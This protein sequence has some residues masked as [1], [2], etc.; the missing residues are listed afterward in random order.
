MKNSTSCACL[1][2]ATVTAEAGLSVADDDLRMQRVIAVQEKPFRLAHEFTFTTGVLPI[3]AFYTGL[4]LGGGYTLHISDLFAW[5]AVSFH[6]S[7]NVDKG[8]D[9]Q[10]AERWS[11]QP[12][13]EPEVEYTLSSHAVIKPL[14]GKLTLFNSSI[15]HAST[16]FAVGGGIAKFTDG[17]RPQ[18]SAGPG[19]R[20][21]WNQ[22]VSSRL[23]LRNVLVPDV[24]D[25]LEYILHV[26]LSVSFNFGSSRPIDDG[27]APR[28]VEQGAAPFAVLD[29]LFPL[30]RPGGTSR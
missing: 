29:E 24:P 1:L 10:L 4:T 2:A 11:V 12:E 17:F 26:Q 22:T 21:F 30:S 14:F 3:D 19:I 16:F 27:D 18:F 23:D 15:I 9:Q 5:E 7:G 20:L 13:G 6:Y 28:S 8:L 25:G